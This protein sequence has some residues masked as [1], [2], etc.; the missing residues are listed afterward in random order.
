MKKFIFHIDEMSYL[1]NGEFNIF[2][3]FTLNFKLENSGEETA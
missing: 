3:T 2:V 1:I